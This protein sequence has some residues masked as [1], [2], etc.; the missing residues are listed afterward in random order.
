RWAPHLTTVS[1]AASQCH[2][3]S[4]YTCLCPIAPRQS[5]LENSEL[6]DA[7]NKSPPYIPTL[8]K[9][10]ARRAAANKE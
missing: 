5:A 9:A 7:N 10:A 6:E 1:L 2:S 3:P 8:T 4:V